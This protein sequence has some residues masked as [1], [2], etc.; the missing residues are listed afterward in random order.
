MALSRPLVLL[1]VAVVAVS[2]LLLSTLGSADAVTLVVNS[3]GDGVDVNPGDGLCDDG[4]GDC[5]L[6]A[7]LEEANVK[8]GTDTIAFNIPG[9]GPHAI[10]PTSPLPVI[11]DP[12][13]IDGYSQPGAS[14]NTN[15]SGLGSNAVLMIELDGTSA[16]P[17]ATG[18]QIT[19]GGTIVRGIA[20]NRFDRDG[21][22]LRVNGGNVVEGS[23]IGTDVTGT[24]ALGNGESGVWISNSDGNTVG[25]ASPAATNLLSGNGVR[26]VLISGS[27]SGNVVEGNLVGTDLTGTVALPNGMVGVNIVDAPRNMVGGTTVGGRNV[28]SGNWKGIEISQDAATGNLV[29]GN[30]VGTQVDG[31]GALGNGSAG[32]VVA[33]GAGGNV[34][35][36][37]EVG[38]SNTIA[39]NGGDGVRVVSG[40]G[41]AIDLNSIFS[42]EQQGIDLN[43]DGPTSN[44]PGDTD[45]GANRG[46]NFPEIISAGIDFDGELTIEYRLDSTAESS[47]YP[48]LVEFFAADGA[49]EEGR[50]FLGSDVYPLGSAR[51]TVTASLG[52]AAGLGVADG[53]L[54]L[55]TATDAVGNTSEFSLP[56]VPV[57]ATC[58]LQVNL[59]FA[60]GIM[61][62]GF[63][64][65]AAQPSTWSVSAIIAGTL[66]PLWSIDLPSLPPITLNISFPIPSVGVVE[67]QSTV[68]VEGQ[69]CAASDAVDTGVP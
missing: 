56:A 25:G 7:A 64:V 14:A 48:L 20:I 22:L 8:A 43:D 63:V 28:I 52:S 4:F 55:A 9:A 6:R 37:G 65:G 62:W 50:T 46:Q 3:S 40:T 39:H 54:V 45:A 30:L 10:Q 21:I 42:N 61:T 18:L 47:A 34:I 23:F 33:G 1:V 26:G 12:L 60:D 31:A 67:V 19:A 35:G 57:T 49:G 13:V 32:I 16:G 69:Q 5:T 11:S 58:T 29:R 44:D 36:G 2:L 68:A 66:I 38:S 27:S 41:N 17:D 15:P 24:S 53:D 59:S 51:T